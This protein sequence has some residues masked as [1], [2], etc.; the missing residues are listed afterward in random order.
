MCYSPARRS[1]QIIDGAL[2]CITN[3]ELPEARRLLIA[4]KIHMEQVTSS[5]INGKS[6]GQRFQEAVAALKTA[7]QS[8]TNINN[9]F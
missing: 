3:G 9:N 5:K 4:A 1:T 2:E 6:I 7:E 8:N